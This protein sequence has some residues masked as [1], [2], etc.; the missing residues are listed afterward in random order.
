M[1]FIDKTSR[2]DAE[3]RGKFL[4]PSCQNEYID[5]SNQLVSD[6]MELKEFYLS[7]ERGNEGNSI[8]A[9]E[10]RSHDLKQQLN[11]ER[12]RVYELESR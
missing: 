1:S 9:Y 5:W 2:S 7:S 6:R 10:W 8:Q 11:E 12:T 4:L 3:E